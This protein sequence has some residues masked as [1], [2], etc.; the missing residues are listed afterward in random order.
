M[1]DHNYILNSLLINSAIEWLDTLPLS[2]TIPKPNATMF[3]V[4]L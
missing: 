3:A 2:Y 1:H 4:E